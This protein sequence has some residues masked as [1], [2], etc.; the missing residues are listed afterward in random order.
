M[1]YRCTLVFNMAATGGAVLI[2]DDEAPLR[3]ALKH[4]LESEGF[5]TLQAK[6]GQEALDIALREHP[7]IILLDLLMPVM[8]G[9]AVLKTLRADSWGRS[10]VVIALTNLSENEQVADLL[11]FGVYEYIVKADWKIEDV[12]AK[13]KEKLKIP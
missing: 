12:V 13:V 4:K 11:E 9:F 6:D 1:M 2:V 10:A 8:D 3:L 7:D 5:E